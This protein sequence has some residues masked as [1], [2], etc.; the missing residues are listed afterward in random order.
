M[1]TY[2]VVPAGVRTKAQEKFEDDYQRDAGGRMV[3]N[4]EDRMERERALKR[5]RRGDDDFDSDDS[6]FE[7]LR[8]VAGLDRAVRDANKSAA[9]QRAMSVKSGGAKSVGGKSVGGKSVGGKS[10]GGKSLGGKSTVVKKG[11]SLHSGD[12]FKAKNNTGG[13]VKGR[14]NVEPY[15]YWQ[16]DRKMLNRRAAKQRQASKSLGGILGGAQQGALKGAKAKGRANA[17]RART[18]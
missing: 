9:V 18:S 12:R 16:F 2:I 15:A 4:D 11:P 8:D 6:D 10:D 17:K 1:T 13:D 14:A 5:K 7:D 3:I